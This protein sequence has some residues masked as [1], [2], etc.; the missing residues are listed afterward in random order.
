[1]TT[2]KGEKPGAEGIP[3]LEGCPFIFPPLPLFSARIPTLIEKKVHFS[4]ILIFFKKKLHRRS[5]KPDPLAVYVQDGKN[6]H[7][8]ERREE[9]KRAPIRIS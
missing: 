3:R 1:M 9:K 6:P 5:G 7:T 2:G 4:P 8:Q